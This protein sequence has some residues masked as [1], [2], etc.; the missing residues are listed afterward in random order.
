[1]TTVQFWQTFYPWIDLLWIPVGWLAVE[2][3]KRLLTTGFVLSCVLLLR[4]QVELMQSIGAPYGFFGFMKSSIFERGLTC[5]GVFIGLF[6]LLAHF[7]KGG[8]KNVHIAAS[9]TILI[10]GFCV[11]ALVMVL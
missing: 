4:L 10:M 7:S 6:L 1:M 2:R 11:S 3:G 9:I 8:D 5:Y